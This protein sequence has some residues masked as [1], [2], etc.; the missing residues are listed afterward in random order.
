MSWIWAVAQ[1]RLARPICD[2][3]D[4][5]GAY[6]GFDISRPAIKFARRTVFG[7]ARIAFHHADLSNL[8]YRKAGGSAVHYRFPAED[9]TIDAAIRDVTVQPSD[10]RTWPRPIWLNVR[11]FLSQAVGS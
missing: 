10:C 6:T 2:Y 7:R 5:R 11:E 4:E 3:L 9:S 1:G 8:E